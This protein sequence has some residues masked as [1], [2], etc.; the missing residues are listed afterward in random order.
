MK[1]LSGLRRR[2]GAAA[3]GRRISASFE[4][5]GRPVDTANNTSSTMN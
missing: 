1:V 5:N 4:I 2:D 3:S